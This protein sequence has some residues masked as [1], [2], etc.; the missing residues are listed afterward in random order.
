MGRISFTEEIR[1]IT[2]DTDGFVHGENYHFYMPSTRQY[3]PQLYQQ[4][5]STANSCIDI[6]DPYFTKE[7]AHVFDL[8]QN[9]DGLHINILTR[10][11]IDKTRKDFDEFIDEV[12]NILKRNKNINTHYHGY[13]YTKKKFDTIWHD[14]YLIIDKEYVYLVGTSIDE[15]INPVKSF[16]IHQIEK[17][18]DKVLILKKFEEC[19]CA[20][21]TINGYKRS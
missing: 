8:V 14:R 4:L 11:S 12:K 13:F 16:G 21:T 5:L 6:W 2:T 20:L 15:Q 10:Q 9:K 19:K 1:G 7:A 18:G 17:K 3:P